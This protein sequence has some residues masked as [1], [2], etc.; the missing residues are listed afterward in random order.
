MSD[1][2]DNFPDAWDIA[3]WG[4]RNGTW[5]NPEDGDRLPDGDE[6]RTS[7]TVVV[8][9]LDND[10]VVHYYSVMD[11]VDGY[12]GLIDAIEDLYEEYG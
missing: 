2:P 12:E 3:G 11:G 1:L 9:Y 7:E 10:N 4:D 8:S 6:L 5:F